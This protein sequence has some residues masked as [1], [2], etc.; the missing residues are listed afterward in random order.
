[1]AANQFVKAKNYSF[2]LLKPRMRS[3]SEIAERL[4]MKEFS[5]EVIAKTLEFLKENNLIDDNEFAKSWIEERK[6]KS[7]GLRK[8]VDELRAKGIKNQVIENQIGYAKHS[9]NESE[10]I[11]KIAEKKLDKLKGIDPEIASSRVYTYLL[12]RGFSAQAVTDTI[13][14]LMHG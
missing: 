1:M 8:I 2:L 13:E 3:E 9:Y 12:R 5:P 4:K 6:R 11:R 10:I 7:L 14:G